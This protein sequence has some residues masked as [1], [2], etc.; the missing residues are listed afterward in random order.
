VI[1]GSS[2][3]ARNNYLVVIGERLEITFNRLY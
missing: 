3:T 1:G 2:H